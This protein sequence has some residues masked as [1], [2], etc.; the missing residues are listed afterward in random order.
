MPCSSGGSNPG[1]YIPRNPLDSGHFDSDPGGSGGTCIDCGNSQE[2]PNAGFGGA[3]L[4]AQPPHIAAAYDASFSACGGGYSG[5]NDIT[6]DSSIGSSWPHEQQTGS[7]SERLL[8]ALLAPSPTTRA[9]S[10][11]PVSPCTDPAAADPWDQVTAGSSPIWPRRVLPDQT[12]CDGNIPTREIVQN[13]DIET[14][15]AAAVVSYL[16]GAELGQEEDAL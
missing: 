10:I 6:H 16:A 5:P 8:G 7:L 2:Q 1:G 15:Y 13:T 11:C 4:P 9:A 3:S 12:A 14:A